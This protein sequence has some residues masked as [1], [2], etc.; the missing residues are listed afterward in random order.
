MT[1]QRFSAHLTHP[2]AFAA[3]CVRCTLPRENEAL[4]AQSWRSRSHTQKQAT[5]EAGQRDCHAVKARK[6]TARDGGRATAF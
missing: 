6:L 2:S 3:I 1:T 5:S 4:P